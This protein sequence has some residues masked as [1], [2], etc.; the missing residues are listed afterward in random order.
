MRLHLSDLKVPEGVEI[1]ALM[2][3]G[4][5]AQSVVSVQAP[6]VETVE[7][8]EADET[9]TAEGEDEGAAASDDAGG[10]D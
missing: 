2:H 1:A 9:A 5:P 4:D 7:P 6:R 10:D 8:T 3:G